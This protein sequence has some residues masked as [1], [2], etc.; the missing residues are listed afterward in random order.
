MALVVSSAAS[1]DNDR[2]LDD[3]TLLSGL[4]RGEDERPD[5]DPGLL[6]C[7]SRSLEEADLKSGGLSLQVSLAN[8][9]PSCADASCW[10][11]LETPVAGAEDALLGGDIGESRN[12][13]STVW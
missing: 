1:G 10:T 11:D 2:G 12:W 13:E 6:R 4:A 7:S 3:D 8:I 9:A 5:D